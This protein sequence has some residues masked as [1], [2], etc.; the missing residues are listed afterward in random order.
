MSAV[1][2]LTDELE[3]WGIEDDIIVFTD[4]SLGFA[5]EFVPVD[6]SCMSPESVEG[7]NTDI[8]Q[9]LNGL[10]AELDFQIVQDIRKYE[11]L[12]LTGFKKLLQSD[13]PPLQQ[14]IC[15]ERTRKFLDY[16][17][18]GELPK[19][20]MKFFVRK[21]MT[22]SL[23][24]KPKFFSKTNLFPK[25][26]EDRFE[27]ELS[28]IK[29]LKK[30][31]ISNLTSMGLQPMDLKS[32][33]VLKELYLFWNPGREIEKEA[34][35][36]NPEDIRSSIVFTDLVVG[37]EGLSLGEWNYKVISLKNLPSHTFAGMAETLSDLPFNSRLC[38]SVHSPNQQKEIDA[39][40]LQRR[41]A[42]SLVH[43]KTEGVSDL[44]SGAKLEE[45]EDLLNEM[46]S[47][48]EKVFYFSLQVILKSKDKLELEEMAS[49]TL[50]NLQQLSGSEGMVESVASFDVFS[51][52]APPNCRA[53]ERRKRVK[54][55]NL[56]NLLPFY[57]AWRGHKAPRVLL[58]SRS[59]NLMHFD[60]FSTELTNPNQIVS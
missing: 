26:T 60:P 57:G 35:S 58:R 4:G 42:F 16:N 5:L 30:D 31:I 34:D 22:Q 41:V 13:A 24:E 33:D 59:G 11:E 6:N 32:D 20:S 50:L 54:T 15:E 1:K 19:Q 46:I 10:P 8:S 51:E 52:V 47:Q 7:L 2:A 17:E 44:E 39:L 37:M 18:Y 48:G 23:M 21:P 27:S 45:L 56:S 36:Y 25:I 12:E 28:K 55:S 9:F 49:Q 43:G 38:V 3:I 53:K 40:K 29:Q 14:K